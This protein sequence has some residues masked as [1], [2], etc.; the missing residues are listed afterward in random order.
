MAASGTF[1]PQSQGSTVPS[2]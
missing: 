1:K 2:Q